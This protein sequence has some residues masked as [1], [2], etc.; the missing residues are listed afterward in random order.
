L[1]Q[2][3]DGC[4]S[5]LVMGDVLPRVESSSIAAGAARIRSGQRFLD[6]DDPVQRVSAAVAEVLAG[7]FGPAS[8]GRGSAGDTFLG[9]L[10]AVRHVEALPPGIRVVRL[11]AGT[12][13]TPLAFDLLRRQ[14][15][16]I[17][18]IGQGELATAAR[19]EWGFAIS[20][21]A[22]S[23]TVQALK[24]SLLEES[25]AWHE[26]EPALERVTSWLVE[27]EGRGAMVITFDA[28]V[29]VWRACQIRGVRAAAAVEPSDVHRATCSLGVNLLV[30]EP[31]GKSIHWM[32]QLGTAFRQ[33]GAPRVRGH[34]LAEYHA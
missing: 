11:Q 21:E 3:F 18:R 31:A 17:R 29:T 6:G 26:L 2:G 15:I 4:E 24:R 23:G 9:K 14:G 22:E 8:T 28:A 16:A 27:R 10:F 1:N 5:D 33:A 20:P 19:G 30:I 25:H 12:V 34:L 32:K 7:G 13:V